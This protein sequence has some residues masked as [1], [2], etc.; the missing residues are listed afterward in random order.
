MGATFQV[1]TINGRKYAYNGNGVVY[2]VE[3]D[4][5]KPVLHYGLEGH[6]FP[7]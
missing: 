5:L 7:N 3:G 2:A 6:E 1:A 4:R